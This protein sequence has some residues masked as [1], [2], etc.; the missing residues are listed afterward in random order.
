M[1]GALTLLRNQGFDMEG[2]VIVALSVAVSGS[3]NKTLK[4]TMSANVVRLIDVFG[5]RQRAKEPLTT[6]FLLVQHLRLADYREVEIVKNKFDQM[7]SRD[8][9]CSA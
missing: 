8:W 2:R 6:L 5:K 7:C 4:M 3:S 9:M 1:S